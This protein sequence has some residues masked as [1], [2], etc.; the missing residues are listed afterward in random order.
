MTLGFKKQF[1]T[2]VEEGSKR[3][4]IRARGGRRWKVGD[5]AD[6]FVN[7]RQ[8][9]MRLL[10]RWRVVKVEP[11]E[12]RPATFHATPSLEIWIA[13]EMLSDDEANALAWRDGFRCNG[14]GGALMQMAGFWRKN[15]GL[16]TFEG[17]LIHWDYDHPVGS[18]AERKPRRSAGRP[19]K[20]A[21]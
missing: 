14:R 16:S 17:D 8:K 20:V 12:I 11:I 13:G 7:P 15:H 4:S 9:S 6:C 10:G 21:V 19:R 1:E 5:V 2:Y 3:H 18:P